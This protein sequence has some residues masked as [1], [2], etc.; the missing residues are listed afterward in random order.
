[1]KAKDLDMTTHY[2]SCASRDWETNGYTGTGHGATRRVRVLDTAPGV[3]VRQSGTFTRVPFSTYRSVSGVRVELLNPESGEPTGTQ[4]VVSSASIRGP[5]DVLWPEV[6]A[7]IEARHAAN[8]LRRASVTAAQDRTT[9][10][11]VR[12]SGLIPDMPGTV[13]TFNNRMNVILDASMIER[14][15]EALEG[16][17]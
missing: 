10:A 9:A 8:A 12:L 11:V 15:C 1:M 4:E 6:A 3:W 16:N 14:I 2:L 5:W 13:T 7:R 17:R